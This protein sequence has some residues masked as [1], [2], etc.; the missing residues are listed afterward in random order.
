MQAHKQTIEQKWLLCVAQAHTN[1]Q[2]VALYKPT[3]KKLMIL[4]I[5]SAKYDLQRHWNPVNEPHRIETHSRVSGGRKKN[6]KFLLTLLP[7]N[8]FSFKHFEMMKKIDTNEQWIHTHSHTHFIEHCFIF[9]LLTD[10]FVC[11]SKKAW[12]DTGMCSLCYAQLC[13]AVSCVSVF[14]LVQKCV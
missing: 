11:P 14:V 13:R 6:N 1:T 9:H 10:W 7:V 4:T 12:L 3:R 5:S 8:W 2:C